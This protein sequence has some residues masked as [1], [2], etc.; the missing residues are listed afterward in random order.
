MVR[1]L[2]SL[3][4]AVGA[5]VVAPSAAVAQTAT[6]VAPVTPADQ[7]AGTWVFVVVTVAV[8][9]VAAVLFVQQRG[10]AGSID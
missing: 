4:V 3:T 7:G 8:V 1:S 5:S 9:A 6:T 10:R 2:L